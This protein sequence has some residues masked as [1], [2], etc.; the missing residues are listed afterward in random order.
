MTAEPQFVNLAKDATADFRLKNTSP[1]I[2][3]GNTIAGQFS[4]SDITGISR[5]IGFSTDMGA[6]EYP[7]VIPRAEINIKQATT[8]I[9]DNTGAYDFGDVASTVP[10]TVLF[11]IE[12]IGDLALNLAGT[13][14]VTV[15]G[16]GFCFR[17]MPQLPLQQI[18]P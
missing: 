13:P 2:N 14:R 16:N 4:A 7:T 15:T 11:T 3:N 18:V 5:P 8:D 12:N 9:V 6:Y 1:A 10:K 17:R